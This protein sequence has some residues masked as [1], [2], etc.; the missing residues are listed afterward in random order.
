MQ[1]LPAHH[2]SLPS[3]WWPQARFTNPWPTW[4]GDKNP[5]DLFAF[6]WEMRQLGAPNWGYLTNNPKPTLE[7]CRWET[8]EKEGL[9]HPLSPCQLSSMAWGFLA[10]QDNE[11][12]TKHSA[13]QRS[14]LAQPTRTLACLTTPLQPAVTSAHAGHP[15][16]PDRSSALHLLP[17]LSPQPSVPAGASRC[18]SAVVPPCWSHPGAVGWSRHC[19]GADGGADLHHRPPVQPALLTCAIHGPTEVRGCKGWAWGRLRGADGGGGGGWWLVVR[20]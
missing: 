16:S 7:D 18:F 13:V 17:P 14:A 15:V 5:R 20:L 2:L 19:A 12:A 8:K 1:T 11:Q 4:T 6:F 3:S 9:S 10:K